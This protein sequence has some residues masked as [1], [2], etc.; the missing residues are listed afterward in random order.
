MDA[1][2]QL[3]DLYT[4][5]GNK[6]KVIEEKFFLADRLIEDGKF[7]RSMQFLEDVLRLK[8]DHHQARIRLVDVYMRCNRTE[9][10]LNEAQALS[11]LFLK[12]KRYSDAIDLYNRLLGIS[13]DNLQLREKLF[14]FYMLKED[15]DKALE[16]ILKIGDFYVRRN[17]YDDAIKL[18]RKALS[19]DE[20]NV[21]VHYAIG[22]LHADHLNEPREAIAAFCRVYELDPS[23]KEGMKRLVGLLLEDNR[24]A[25]AVQ[26]LN[27]LIKL[28]R[29]N[30][31][32]RDEII[33]EYKRRVEEHP[34][35]NQSRYVL[36]VIYKELGL[37]DNAI[38][39]F[40]RTKKVPELLLQS[41]DM[42]GMCFERKVGFN[43]KE[44]AIKQFKKGLETKGYRDEEYQELRYNLAELYNRNNMLTEAQKLYQD[45]FSV[46]INFK[47]VKHKLQ[48]IQEELSGSSKITR[49][50]PRIGNQ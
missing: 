11:E 32:V 1:H 22:V 14:Q 26:V 36:G 30:E 2:Q 44:I 25:E 21:G 39:Q 31:L 23:H 19:L 10:A 35:D 6:E 20:R 33:D 46:D 12:E 48:Q 45:C 5:A 9:N 27:A 7:D 15:K 47:D 50:P 34:E 38:E 40:Q 28:D 37:L 16:E 18:Y 3:I 4:R 17:Q 29:A 13:P 43:M 42:L 41:Y 8:G 49:L 24:P